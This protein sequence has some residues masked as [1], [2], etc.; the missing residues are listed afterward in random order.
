M[1]LGKSPARNLVKSHTFSTMSWRY[2]RRCSHSRRA[3]ERSVIFCHLWLF[4]KSCRTCGASSRPNSVSQWRMWRHYSLVPYPWRW[5][6]T[7]SP[8]LGDIMG[9]GLSREVPL[10]G[11][12][13]SP[14]NI[15]L[16]V[17]CLD[18]GRC[19]HHSFLRAPQDLGHHSLPDHTHLCP[20]LHCHPLMQRGCLHLTSYSPCQPWTIP[21]VRGVTAET[22]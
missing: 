7:L 13:K 10:L 20:E 16:L 19:P 18:N 14:R 6:A 3:R 21:E 11:L 1:S 8:P 15:C 9:Q 4:V 12:N 5:E 17:G 22:K 2:V